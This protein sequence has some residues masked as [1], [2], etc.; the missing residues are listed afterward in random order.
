MLRKLSFRFGHSK[1]QIQNQKRDKEL[2]FVYKFFCGE[3]KEVLINPPGVE[4]ENNDITIFGTSNNVFF[5][6]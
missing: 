5:N 3:T 1:R 2:K 6:S 4:K